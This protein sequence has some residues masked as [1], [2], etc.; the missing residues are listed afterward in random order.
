MGD[1]SITASEG[2]P[3]SAGPTTHPPHSSAARPI[4][5][6]P[7]ERVIPWRHRI[8]SKLL[9]VTVVICVA[10]V[11]I[12]AIA[13]GRM[14]EQFFETQVAGAALFGST[15]ERATLRAMLENRRNDV[16]D[17]IR[18]IGRQEGVEAVR[19]LA[20][21]GRVAFS[22]VEREVGTVFD[23]RSDSCRPC[24]SAGHPRVHAPLLERTRVYSRGDH[25]VL[26]LVAPIRNE[27]RCASADCHVH[28][29]DEDVLGLLDVSL[30]L[31]SSDARVADFRRGSLVLTGI[32]VLLL[33]AFFFAF[34]RFHVVRP[35]QALVDGTRRVAIDQL[36]TEIRVR[37]KGELGLL[38]ASFNDMTRALRRTEGELKDLNLDLERQVDE[39]TADLKKAQNAL[40]HTEKMSSLG[41]LAASIAHE[42]N[43]PLAGILTFAKLVIRTLEQGPPDEATR[44]DLVRN[45]ALVQRETERCSAIVRNL[46]DF[47]RDRPVALRE[48]QVNAVVEEALQLIAHQIAIQGLTLEKDLQPTPPVLADFGQLRQAVVNVTMNAVEAMGKRGTLSVRTRARADG[49]VEIAISDTGPGIAAEHLPHVFEPFFTTKEKGTGLGLSVVY[50][51]LQRHQGDVEVQSEVGRGTT[52]TFS[53]PPPA[54]AEAQA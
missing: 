37:S 48:L 13:E 17:T 49:G 33:S 12:F 32:G 16:F 44:R 5:L 39:R 45:L 28:R 46:L 53:L 19:L 6:P 4:P 14:Q 29:P 26:G 11:A 25:R 52:F 43:N 23:Q 3:A 41:Q 10:G 27:P 31:A 1:A 36:D 8:K 20:K 40:V 34:A 35:V 2:S 18:D 9:I 51:I 47:A 15:I 38:A 54:A 24:H 42:I 21:D 50:G 30:S 7:I 22:S